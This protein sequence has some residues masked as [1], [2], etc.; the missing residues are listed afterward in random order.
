MV[1]NTYTFDIYPLDVN[2]LF[3]MLVSGIALPVS[4]FIGCVS[5]LTSSTELFGITELI[6]FL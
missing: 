6:W 1:D 5:L 2:S 4:D 3:A